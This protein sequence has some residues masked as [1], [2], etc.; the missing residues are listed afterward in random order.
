MGAVR[1]EDFHRPGERLRTGE[2][3]SWQLADRSGQRWTRYRY[4]RIC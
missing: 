4:L 2:R 3:R 1:R